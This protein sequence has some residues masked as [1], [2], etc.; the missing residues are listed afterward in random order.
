V[1]PHAE[2]ARVPQHE[3]GEL[4]HGDGTDLVVEAVRDRRTDRVLRHV[5]AS[6]V[7]VGHAVAGRG[8]STSFHDV[9]GLPRAQDHLADTTHRL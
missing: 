8:A 4:A 5:A 9:S 7:V 3:V 2:E 6:A 1:G